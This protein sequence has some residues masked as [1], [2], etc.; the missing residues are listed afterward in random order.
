MIKSVIGEL[1]KRIDSSIQSN[2]SVGNIDLSKLDEP[3]YKLDASLTL[4]ELH[5]AMIN[6]VSIS[7]TIRVLVEANIKFT[8]LEKQAIDKIL[9]YSN[10]DYLQ[11]SLGILDM[12]PTTL[13]FLNTSLRNQNNTSDLTYYT[14]PVSSSSLQTE[15]DNLLIGRGVLGYYYT[16]SLFISLI[17]NIHKRLL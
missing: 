16:I 1:K 3:S 10:A 6:G 8:L 11:S 2:R 17:T 12:H 7:N 15:I 14:N 9:L 13:R 4:K 5:S